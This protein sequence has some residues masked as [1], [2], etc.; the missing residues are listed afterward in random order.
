MKTSNDSNM[1]TT[2]ECKEKSY[3]NLLQSPKYLNYKNLRVQSI[4]K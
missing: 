1:I 4:A 2:S 3:S